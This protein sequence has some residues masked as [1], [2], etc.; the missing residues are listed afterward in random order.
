MAGQKAAQH[1][2]LA[3]VFTAIV[4]F[5]YGNSYAAETDRVYLFCLETPAD[6][7]TS[8]EPVTQVYVINFIDKSF[9]PA[10]HPDDR[11]YITSDTPTEIRWERN[12]HEV[13]ADGAWHNVSESGRVDRNT[14]IGERILSDTSPGTSKAQKFTLKCSSGR[15]RF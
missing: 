12:E 13:S 10:G 1:L 2:S 5:T 9:A 6:N 11:G 4:T 8:A 15:D 7:P 14:G 3:V